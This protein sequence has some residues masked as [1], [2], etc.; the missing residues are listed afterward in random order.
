[1]YMDG[2][3]CSQM[4]MW[5]NGEY[6]TEKGFDVYYDLNWFKISGLGIDGMS[7]RF[8][9]LQTLWPNIVVKTLPR[10]KTKFYKHFLS[11]QEMSCMLPHPSAIKRSVYFRGYNNL[12][13]QEYLRL[14]H[15]NFSIGT[16]LLTQNTK[17]PKDKIYSGVHVRRGDLANVSNARYTQP[18]DGY[19]LRAIEYVQQHAQIDE[20]LLF[21]E[22]SQWLKQNIVPHV[23]VPCRVM[24]NNRGY[25]DLILLA[26]CEVIISSQG[27]FGMT[28][29]LI[30]GQC[31][32]FVANEKRWFEWNLAKSMV[33]VE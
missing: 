23:S 13:I 19:F 31:S 17:L 21:S 15:K 18:N 24:E 5:V 29:A 11:W 6:Y 30:N 20:Y 25:E 22:D 1:M 12:H 8:Y 26:Q 27:S 14:Y 33:V 32:L 16:A 7:P 4:G 9:E 3:L 28:A 10:W 2:G